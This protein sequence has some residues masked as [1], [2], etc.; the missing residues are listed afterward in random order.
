MASYM[1]LMDIVT[2][3]EETLPI[4][5]YRHRFH[6]KLFSIYLFNLALSRT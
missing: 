2:E 4:Y 3:I 6:N 5:E 1:L